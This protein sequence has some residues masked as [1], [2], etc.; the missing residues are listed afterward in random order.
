[1]YVYI[2]IYIYIYTYIS[3]H[4]YVMCIIHIY[5][6]VYTSLSLYIYIYIHMYITPGLC[7]DYAAHIGHNFMLQT[8]SRDERVVIAKGQMGSALMGPLR[9]SFLLTYF[10]GTPVNICLSSP[11]C[12][13]VPFFNLSKSLLLKRPH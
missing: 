9:I 7:V 8:G 1:M 5:I 4:T 2:Y 13:G 3:T 12:Q 6:Y 10:L 11:K